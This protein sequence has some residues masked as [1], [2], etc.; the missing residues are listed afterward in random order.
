MA[1]MQ[2]TVYPHCGYPSPSAGQGQFAGQRPAFCQ[3]CYA[4]NH[5]NP[6]QSFMS[7]QFHHH[8]HHHHHWNTA[9]KMQPWQYERKLIDI[10]K[11]NP[12]NLINRL[13]FKDICYFSLALSRLR[14]AN[15][16]NDDDDDDDDEKLTTHKDLLWM[17]IINKFKYTHAHTELVSFLY[18]TIHSVY[19]QLTC[20]YKPTEVSLL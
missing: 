1:D 10:S 20:V 19:S 8:H 15:C 11:N 13:L 17:S 6:K 12:F 5:D 18:D 2:R 7:C 16:F 4:T 9:D 3:L 14:F